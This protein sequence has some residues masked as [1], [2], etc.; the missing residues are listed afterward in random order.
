MFLR[1]RS[2]SEY[3]RVD[4]LGSCRPWFGRGS[5]GESAGLHLYGW[6]R[7][8]ADRNADLNRLRRKQLLDVVFGC[9]GVGLGRGVR[10]Q[11]PAGFWRNLFGIELDKRA[12]GL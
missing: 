3:G 12:V 10:Y 2:G 8:F 1:A 7:R 4:R 5:N 9:A 6:G 11:Y